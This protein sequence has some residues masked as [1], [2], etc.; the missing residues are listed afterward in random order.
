MTQVRIQAV[1][2]IRALVR[3][4]ASYRIHKISFLIF[5]FVDTGPCGAGCKYPSLILVTCRICKKP[6]HHVCDGDT[7][8]TSICAKCAGHKIY[9][10]LLFSKTN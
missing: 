1:L 4:V 3:K 7:G 9:S 8:D 2:L 10:K 5:F 6:H